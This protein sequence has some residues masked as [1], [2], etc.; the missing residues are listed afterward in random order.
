MKILFIGDFSNLH[1]C[2]GAGLRRKGHEVTVMSDGCG[3]IKS[4]TDI[5][6]DRKPGLVGSIQY[7]FQIFSLLP[8]LK[9][10]DVV[11]LMS[12]NFLLLRPGKLKYLFNKLRQQN[13]KVYVTLAGDDHFFMK[14]CLEGKVFK[15]SEYK[16][17]DQLTEYCRANPQR[18]T[19]WMTET[20]RIWNSWVYEQIDGAMSVLPEYDMVA[21]PILGDKLTF[22][23]LPVDL[24]YLPYSP[25]S[26]EDSL[27]IFIGMRGGMEV[28]KGTAHML[29]IAKELEREIPGKVQV[30]CVRNMPLKDYIER[31]KK[32][33]LVLDQLYAYSPATNALQAMALGKAVGTGAQPEY[34]D[35]INHHSSHPLLSLSPIDPEPLKDRLRKLILDPTPLVE[36]GCESRK[37]IEKHNDV[38]VV[39][40]RFL[41][42]WQR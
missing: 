33:H 25:L 42:A 21:R 23:N 13:G 7:L 24:T 12:P 39:A 20:N 31:M 6:L 15:Y 14:A 22:T 5:L 35:Y 19:G 40:N 34:Y 28:L 3:Y 8:Q 9:G 32:S 29:S 41:S 10:Y 18:M 2:L 1:S 38:S 36:M 17:G 30:E 37:I 27:K 4:E 26:I 16:I 11:Q